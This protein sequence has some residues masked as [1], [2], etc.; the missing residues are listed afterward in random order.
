MKIQEIVKGEG[1]EP[2]SFIVSMTAQEIIYLEHL[3]GEKSRVTANQTMAGG[4]KL[5]SEIYRCL[6]EHRYPGLS[7]AGES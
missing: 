4:G 5:N 3:T 2:E 6:I 1:G 7:L